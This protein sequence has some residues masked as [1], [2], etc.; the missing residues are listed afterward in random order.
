MNWYPLEL[1]QG[2]W[3]VPRA[4]DVRTPE[5]GGFRILHD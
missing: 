2:T 5:H 4:K 3:H 1:R